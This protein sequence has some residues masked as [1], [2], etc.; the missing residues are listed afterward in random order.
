MVNLMHTV[1][2]CTEIDPHKF[3]ALAEQCNQSEVG[4]LSHFS[5]KPYSVQENQK[6]LS[7]EA[8]DL[9]KY[10]LSRNWEDVAKKIG[11]PDR[12]IKKLESKH[13][14]G[15]IAPPAMSTNFEQGYPPLIAEFLDIS[16]YQM[17][18]PV[19]TILE[20][21]DKY[22]SYK[23][24]QYA[25]VCKSDCKKNQS[26][27]SSYI[28]LIWIKN[29]NTKEAQ[30]IPNTQQ[31]PVQQTCVNWA[32]FNPDKLVTLWYD[33][34][35][36][37]NDR[38]MTDIESFRKQVGTLNISNLLLLDIA[39][40][41]WGD[42]ERSFNRR[43]GKVKISDAMH[44]HTPTLDFS[45]FIDGLRVLFLSMG[46]ACISSAGTKK[47]PDLCDENIPWGG[48]YFDID[49][50]PI[51]FDHY[52]SNK[53]LC[54]DGTFDIPILIR[55]R[56][57]FIAEE[58]A[59]PNSMLMTCCERHAKPV[60][61]SLPLRK[62]FGEIQDLANQKPFLFSTTNIFRMTDVHYSLEGKRLK[63]ARKKT[64]GDDFK[65]ETD[66]VPLSMPNGSRS[67]FRLS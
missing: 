14:N 24:A 2:S 1:N 38:D 26:G 44:P 46:H 25:A 43:S 6:K 45:H 67:S 65:D 8:I 42:E 29:P 19:D 7:Q 33:S 52:H 22:G 5:V 4:T 58:R 15:I 59:L 9:A 56:K 53:P 35:T 40:I 60:L 12:E 47:N 51:Q 61:A 23:E 41:E 55:G 36:F 39:H 31:R 18:I 34:R 27:Y 30:S 21:L 37:T 10:R 20:A 16:L 50:K 64:W 57:L 11:F 17:K 66:S 3:V 54:R 63:W 28:F 62:S 49:Y 32:I 48:A 13:L